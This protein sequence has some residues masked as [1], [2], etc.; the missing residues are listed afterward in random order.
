MI[1]LRV[2]WDGSSIRRLELKGHAGFSDVGS[3]I[4]CAGVSALVYNAV[5]SCEALLDVHLDV[6]DSNTFVC[7]VPTVQRS[8][9]TA[10]GVQLLLQSMHLGIQQIADQYPSNVRV[11][12]IGRL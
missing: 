6:Q 5:N 4:V 9:E 11:V 3:D 12:D 8:S 10:N 7:S 2:E 1:E